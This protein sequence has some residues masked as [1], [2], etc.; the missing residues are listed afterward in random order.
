MKIYRAIGALK[1][2]VAMDANVFTSDL[3]M[4]FTEAS[5]VSVNLRTFCAEFPLN[6]NINLV[7]SGGDDVKR[8]G[9]DYI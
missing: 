9:T 3:F 6:K 8:R 7:V 1:W 4:F 2:L 5:H